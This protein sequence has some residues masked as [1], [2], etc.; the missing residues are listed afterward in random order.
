MKLSKVFFAVSLLTAA[1][2]QADDQ[3][4]KIEH[5]E[6]IGVAEQSQAFDQQKLGVE[7][8]VIDRGTIEQAGTSD[9]NAILQQSVPGLTALAKN[10][11]Y[12][13][14]TYSLQGSRSKDILWLIDGVRINNRLFGSGYLDTI[15][16]AMIERIEVMK[17]GQSVLYGT[18]AL[19]GVINVVT[20]SYKG[21]DEAQLNVGIDSLAST[22]LS[23]YGTSKIGQTEV[24]VFGASDQSDGYQPFADEDMHWTTTDKNRGY[25]VQNLGVKLA[26]TLGDT[27]LQLMGQFNKADLDYARPYYNVTTQNKREQTLVIAQAEHKVN[28]DHQVYLKAYYHKWDTDYFR[29]YQYE[30][31]S[32]EVIN[33]NDPWWFEDYGAKL[34]ITSNLN[35]HQLRYGIEQQRYYGEDVVMDFESNTEIATDVFMQY[36]PE[37][38]LDNTTVSIGGRHTMITDGESGNAFEISGLHQLTDKWAIKLAT[39]T[40]FSLPT[41]EQ[42]YTKED[43]STMGNR[44]LTPE[45]GI[46]V[47]LGVDYNNESQHWATNLFWRQISNLIG[48]GQVDGNWQYMNVGQEVVTQGIDIST[49]QYL[50]QDINLDVAVTYTNIQDQ[51][52]V[53]AL[54][55]IPDLTA[56]IRLNYQPVDSN[57]NAWLH[58]NYVGTMS[59]YDLEYG[60]YTLVDLG[61]SLNFGNIHNQTVTLKV[62]NLL[63]TENVTGLFNPASS[64]PADFYDGPIDVMG[65]PRNIQLNY[66]YKF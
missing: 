66:G 3:S 1:N 9:L 31:K 16:T 15:S 30:D 52:D 29:L 41:A 53:D 60:E 6:I 61:W 27:R 34:Q 49:V 12:D 64:A 17:A 32:V 2:V 57:W 62:E 50:T 37:L 39:G 20:R 5:L 55:D 44:N 58:A 21:T 35:G 45:E 59:K 46:N 63:D 54:L 11:R 7:L 23:G 13:Y 8:V 47:N 28:A 24:T 18:T 51:D 40:S 4:Q 38:G 10:G 22:Q 56:N 25:D 14:A 42:L 48:S 33:D 65:T 26:Q 43:G 19:A 36:V